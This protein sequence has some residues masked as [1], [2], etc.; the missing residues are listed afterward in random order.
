MDEDY[1]DIGFMFS[2]NHSRT[3]KIIE[4]SDARVGTIYLQL[5]GEDP[6][7]VQS[8]QYLWPAAEAASLHLID[9]WNSISRPFMKVVELGAGCGLTGIVASKLCNVDQH[10]LFTDY[11][12]GSLEIINN[13]AER[14]LIHGQYSVQNIKWGLEID[15]TMQ[16]QF[17][18][19]I[20]SD[21]LYS[22]DIVMPLFQSVYDLMS[23]GNNNGIF[24]LV[25]SFDVGQNIEDE[26]LLALQKFRFHCEE[27]ASLS[28]IPCPGASG[29]GTKC[30]IQYFKKISS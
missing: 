29:V 4:F 10:I 5:I 30:R 14:N 16:N 26:I 8:G 3:E 20:G 27:I 1:S 11:D 25:S 13:N 7:H 19:I 15:A 21:L 2:S 24:I 28:L 22:V 12:Y 6:G 9:I 18:I 23:T 17:D